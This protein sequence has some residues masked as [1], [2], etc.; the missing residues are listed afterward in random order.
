[1]GSAQ[2]K[3]IHLHGAASDLVGAIRRLGG[4]LEAEGQGELARWLQLSTLVVTGRIIEGRLPGEALDRVEDT[5]LIVARWLGP[6]PAVLR[7]TQAVATIRC[8]SRA[9]ERP[10]RVVRSAPTTEAP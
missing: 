7:G 1:M 3:N 6:Q 4:A 9:P 8:W 10:P 5:L 2:R